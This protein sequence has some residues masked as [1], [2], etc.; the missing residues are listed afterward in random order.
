[1]TNYEVE[2]NLHAKSEDDLTNKLNAIS[3]ITQKLTSEELYGLADILQ[4]KPKV[5]E[6][7]RPIL[8]EKKDYS[9]ADI[10]KMTPGIY[11]TLK[12]SA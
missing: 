1:M 6:I 8:S 10:I 9:I 5:M 4:N 2:I 11:K 7:I 12:N 3:I